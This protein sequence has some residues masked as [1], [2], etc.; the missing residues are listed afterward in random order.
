[1]KKLFL[2][3]GLSFLLVA[4]GGA[5]K[6]TPSENNGAST[7]AKNKVS[8]NKKEASSVSDSQVS[9]KP[10]EAVK[11]FT[12]KYP[13]ASIEEIS[14]ERENNTLSY[15]ISANDDENEYEFKI[16]AQDGSII[17]DEAE[18]GNNTDGTVDLKHLVEIENYVEKSLQ[19]AGDD[20]TLN[21]WSFSYEDE[22]YNV[23][24]IDLK[25]GV[26]GEIEY[27]YNLDTGDAERE[28]D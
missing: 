4:C 5:G 11:I 10:E 22:K 13:D 20:F 27:R 24:S 3:V 21:E 18:K 9:L 17:K 7:E 26:G 28:I 25:N 1:M 15:E 14:F 6:N 23:L 19:E 16:N 12:D 2:T 8:D